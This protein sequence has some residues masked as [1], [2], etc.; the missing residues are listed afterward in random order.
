MTIQREVAELEGIV[1]VEAQEATKRVTIEWNEPPTSW[2]TI[3][4]LLEEI[5]YPPE[6]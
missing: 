3:Q 4:S 6:G 1:S 5:N 2:G